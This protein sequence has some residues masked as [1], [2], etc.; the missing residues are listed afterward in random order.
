MDTFVVNSAYFAPFLQVDK[1]ICFCYHSWLVAFY[2][3]YFAYFFPTVSAIKTATDSLRTPE[4]DHFIIHYKQNANRFR[5]HAGRETK[6]CYWESIVES[7]IM[8]D[9][10]A[11]IDGATLTR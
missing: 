3:M 1:W 10:H 2:Y 6:N 5:L 7:K 9:H 11:G 4:Q 8:A